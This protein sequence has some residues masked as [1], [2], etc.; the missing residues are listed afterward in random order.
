M[1]PSAAWDS[2]TLKRDVGLANTQ[3]GTPCVWSF[4]WMSRD[5]VCALFV[6]PNLLFAVC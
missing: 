3:Q 1:C 5:K 6:V 4:R 2:S